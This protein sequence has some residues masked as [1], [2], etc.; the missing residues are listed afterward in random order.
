ME[1]Q[2]QFYKLAESFL[3]RARNKL[4][5]ARDYSEKR[6]S[7]PESIS[8]SQECIELSLKAIFLLVGEDYPKEHEL[9]DKEFTKVLENIPKELEYLNWVRVI[10][11]SRFWSQ[12][13]TVVKYGHDRFKIGAE[14][15]FKKEEAEL[16][17]K[18]AE[19]CFQA[20]EAL[21][22]YQLRKTLFHQK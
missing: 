8:A 6:W 12:F 14:Q 22:S 2:K 15:L 4:G 20:G 19:E 11:V 13:Y 7:Y 10:V 1:R 17:K 3:K 18:H 9:R 5:E 21:R 16:A